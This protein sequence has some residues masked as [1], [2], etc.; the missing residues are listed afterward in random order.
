MCLFCVVFCF[1]AYIYPTVKTKEHNET[2]TDIF[3]GSN[4]TQVV[5]YSY[6]VGASK[7]DEQT[8]GLIFKI[9]FYTQAI[10]GKFLPCI[11][12]VTFSSLLVHSLIIINRN[13]KKL[14]KLNTTFTRNINAVNMTLNQNSKR[15]FG[16]ESSVNNN[17]ND[18]EDDDKSAKRVIIG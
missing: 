2:V 3:G 17:K 6:Y 16:N 7:L 5:R 4:V 1:P 10:F 12:L 9:L 13:N 15:Q 14:N 18:N 11:L 8:N